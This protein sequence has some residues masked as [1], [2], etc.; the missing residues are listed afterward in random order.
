MVFFAG[1]ADNTHEIY[2]SIYYAELEL[3]VKMYYE[4]G[5]VRFGQ[6]V[7]G[8]IASY[9]YDGKRHCPDPRFFYNDTEVF[10]VF[11][12]VVIAD[13]TQGVG[14]NYFVEKGQ[15]EI[16]V[17]ISSQN[18]YNEEYVSEQHFTIIID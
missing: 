13:D 17:R 5:D 1:C 14:L 8:G 2:K 9:Q 11:K 6:E 3:E 15:Y 16:H 4:Y 12:Y 7:E 18:K 10:P